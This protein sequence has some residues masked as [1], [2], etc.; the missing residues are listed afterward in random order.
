M[1]SNP[2]AHNSLAFMAQPSY[3][4][5]GFG[6]FNSSCW[7]AAHRMP[8][9]NRIRTGSLGAD[10]KWARLYLL[11]PLLLPPASRQPAD[12]RKIGHKHLILL[13]GAPGLEPG[14]R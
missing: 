3:Q 13:V 11:L 8:D 5:A 9:L 4:R 2:T 14:T 12:D 6:P 7:G 1:A 10:L